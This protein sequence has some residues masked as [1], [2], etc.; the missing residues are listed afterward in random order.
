VSPQQ[1]VDRFHAMMRDEFQAFGMSFDHY[2]R[3]S[4]KIHHETSQEFFRVMDHLLTV[5]R[6]A[7]IVRGMRGRWQFTHLEEYNQ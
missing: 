7:T 3:T 6:R 1:V 4:T 5:V 2:G